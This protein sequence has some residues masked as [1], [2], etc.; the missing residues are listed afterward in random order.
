MDAYDKLLPAGLPA[1]H[2]PFWESL[3][4][5]SVRVQ[6]C[7]DCSLFRYVPKEVC[8]RCQ[9]MKATWTPVS[10]RGEVYTHTTVYRAPTPAFQ[11]DAPYV[12]A[13]VT[14]EEGFRMVGWLDVTDPTTARIGLSVEITYNDVSPEWTLFSFR[15]TSS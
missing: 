4:N 13:H 15:P 11:A 10:G 12:I 6:R 9:S 5:H 7:D 8:P 14:M 3:R 1:W 2:G